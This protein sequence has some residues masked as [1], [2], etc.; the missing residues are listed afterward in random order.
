MTPVMTKAP[1]IVQVMP[2]TKFRSR[3]DAS[4]FF[5]FVRQDQL[6][7]CAGAGVHHE[8]ASAFVRASRAAE[9]MS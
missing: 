3:R 9:L 1:T 4:C 5:C 7:A 2:M 8:L 6:A